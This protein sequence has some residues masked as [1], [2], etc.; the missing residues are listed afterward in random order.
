MDKT[1]DMFASED[2]LGFDENQ[3]LMCER[4]NLV[5]LILYLKEELGLSKGES[6]SSEEEHESHVVVEKG[7]K[8]KISIINKN[9]REE[10]DKTETH[11]KKQVC[12][13][14]GINETAD[15]LHCLAYIADP[16]AFFP[17][18]SEE[19]K[20]L[21]RMIQRQLIRQCSDDVLDKILPE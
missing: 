7:S 12:I 2:M 8:E 5:Q 15:L 3:Y 14:L 13:K 16:D 4:P 21:S 18:D 20:V 6:E 9:K 19:T 1:E 10:M 11:N 17:P